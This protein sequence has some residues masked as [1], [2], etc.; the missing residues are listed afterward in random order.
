MT[1]AE[2]ATA[3]AD[4]SGSTNLRLVI[5]AAIVI[6]LLLLMLT[7]SL[8]TVSQ[9]VNRNGKDHF[10]LFKS[11]FFILIGIMLVISFFSILTI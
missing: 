8:L 10:Q 1:S 4:G 11:I 3:F 2:I 9:E 5:V 6:L 7:G